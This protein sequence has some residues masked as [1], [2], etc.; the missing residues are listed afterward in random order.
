MLA[1]RGP[2]QVKVPTI[3]LE[4]SRT[5]ASATGE[6]WVKIRVDVPV[7]EEYP[8]ASAAMTAAVEMFQELR[9]LYPM[10]APQNGGKP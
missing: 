5:S 1:Q 7:C 9:E 10:P 6:E 2:S 8:T 4:R 3:E